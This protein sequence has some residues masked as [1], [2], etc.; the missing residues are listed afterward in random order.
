[1]LQ[2][3]A[4]K[5]NQGRPR[6]TAIG[7]G[8][9]G[10]YVKTVHNG[11]E[12]GM[13]SAL[14]EV[15]YL[16][17]TCLEMTYEEVGEVFGR[18]NKTSPLRDNFLIDVGADMHRI[19]DEQGKYVLANVRDKVVQDVNES[20]GTGIWTCEETMS[21]G[22]SAATIVSGHMF[23]L[24]SAEGARRAKIEKSFA[25]SIPAASV[26]VDAIGWPP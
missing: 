19:K 3:V 24:T 2:R 9:S 18:W 10:H 23:R 11:I 22:V 7:P 21:P 6:T 26:R 5:D 15:W 13:M 16:M 4:A 25:K 20:E 1:L 8:G 14:A 17:T 12:Q